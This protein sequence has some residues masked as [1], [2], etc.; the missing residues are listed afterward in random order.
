MD[1]EKP[2]KISLEDKEESVVAWRSTFIANEVNELQS[3]QRS[4][5]PETTLIWFLFF[6]VGIGW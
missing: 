3:Q 4:I 1:W 6:W 2:R 5:S